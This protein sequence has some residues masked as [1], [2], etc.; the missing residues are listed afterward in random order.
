MGAG[1]GLYHTED[2]FSRT[3]NAKEN[4]SESVIA[5]LQPIMVQDALEI[6]IKILIVFDLP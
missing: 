3:A 2:V 5:L 4:E 1:E 6:N